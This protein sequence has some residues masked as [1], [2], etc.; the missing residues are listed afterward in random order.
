MNSK[1]FYAKLTSTT[2]TIQHFGHS[3]NKVVRQLLKLMQR[4][5]FV[6]LVS[7]YIGGLTRIRFNDIQGTVSKDKNEILFSRFGINYNEIMPRYR[8]GS[9]FVRT[10]VSAREGEIIT[11]LFLPDRPLKLPYSDRR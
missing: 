3:S 1:T 6:S 10:E 8:K 11:S 9:V 7:R 4:F 5:G 2:Y